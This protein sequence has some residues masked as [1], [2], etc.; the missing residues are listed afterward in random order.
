VQPGRAPAIVPRLRLLIVAAFSLEL[1][2]GLKLDRYL[3]EAA[4]KLGNGKA[5]KVGFLENASYPDSGL[6]VAQVAFWDEFG[7]SKTPA[8]PFMRTTIA[9]KKGGWGPALAKIA[10]ATNYDAAKTM[11]QMGGAIQGQFQHAINEWSDP[12]NAESTVARKGFNKP[13]I[14]TAHMIKHVDYEV[15]G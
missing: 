5:V 7:T 6:P 8:R 4:E 11:T 13:L 1:K 15:I 2:G 10:K 12:P 3:R 9:N 14:D